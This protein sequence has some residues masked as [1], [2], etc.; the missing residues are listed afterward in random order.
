[1]SVLRVPHLLQK[2]SLQRQLRAE[3]MRKEEEKGHHE[4][5]PERGKSYLGQQLV[6]SPSRLLEPTSSSREDRGYIWPS[7]AHHQN[8]SSLLE[9]VLDP[10]DAGWSNVR[11]TSASPPQAK[12][13]GGST[14]PTCLV[15]RDVGDRGSPGLQA[16][17]GDADRKSVV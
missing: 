1:M 12:P 5:E 13:G 11:A 9:H 16:E 10:A 14:P 8:S 15:C 6:P 7:Q 3:V 17:V 4:A 2:K